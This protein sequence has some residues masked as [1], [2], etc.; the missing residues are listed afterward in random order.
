M[1]FNSQKIGSSL[2]K[3]GT[4]DGFKTVLWLIVLA[5]VIYFAKQIFNIINGFIKGGPSPQEQLEIEAAKNEFNEY[6]RSFRADP[7][8]TV[9]KSKAL[10]LDKLF[11]SH[12][13][14]AV[15]IAKIITSMT[16]EQFVFV[17]VEYGIKPNEVWINSQ[18]DLCDQLL[19][20]KDHDVTFLFKKGYYDKIRNYILVV[21]NTPTVIKRS[22][23]SAR[24]KK[25]SNIS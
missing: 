13:P 10:E 20:V 5:F 17:F 21:A 11:Q 8:P 3:V 2:K 23:L 16:V 19:K 6:K 9:T 15:A 1:K 14:D 7:N 4:K 25:I 18:G 22:G 24:M 12:L